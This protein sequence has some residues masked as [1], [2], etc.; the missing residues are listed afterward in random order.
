MPLNELPLA[1]L[2]LFALMGLAFALCMFGTALLQVHGPAL[3]E[4][5]RGYER[6][7]ARD[8][9]FLRAP[10]C[11]RALV[12]AQALALLF[13]LVCFAADAL[14]PSSVLIVFV[15]GVRPFVQARRARRV[16]ELEAQLDGWLQ[17]LASALRA[18]PALGE[19]IAQTAM[20]TA[21]PL[22]D[23]LLT[24]VQEVQLGASLD[25]AIDR[26]VVRVG[27]RTFQS[28]LSTL[29]I[30]R[31]TGGDLSRILERSAAT[32]REL[33]RLEGVVRTKT[34]EAKAQAFVLAALPLPLIGLLTYMNP[35][36]LEPLFAGPRGHLV[37]TAA[38]IS[39]ACSIAIA[40]VIL[41]V[42]I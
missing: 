6:E 1:W 9:A 22:R 41:R 36:F 23:E 3:R 17:S 19:A 31:N 38:F 8:L 20:L 15:L 30:G 2:R 11:A 12:C 25:E 4:R 7:L 34:A 39:W 18:T 28:A 5:V 37:L 16:T 21:P 32:L 33:A 27:S 35:D 10:P 26:A 29:H 42:D 13:S 24:L 40:R 14:L